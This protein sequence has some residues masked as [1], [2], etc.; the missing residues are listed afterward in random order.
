MKILMKKKTGKVLTKY[1]YI[2][3]AYTHTHTLTRTR[4]R[5]HTHTHAPSPTARAIY[6]LHTYTFH[7]QLLPKEKEMV[8]FEDP[9]AEALA[10]M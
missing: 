9:V 6:K 10:P 1:T 7:R 4:T 3:P 2:L 5:T 8:Y